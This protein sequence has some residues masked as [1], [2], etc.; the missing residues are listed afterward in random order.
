M[1]NKII[2]PWFG[3]V[4]LIAYMSLLLFLVDFAE[5]TGKWWFSLV[6]M[7]VIMFSTIGAVSEISKERKNGR[8]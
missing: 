1:K 4:I 7:C 5:R 3:M 8:I 6:A 2:N